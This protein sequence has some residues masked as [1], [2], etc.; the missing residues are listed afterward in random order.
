M[1]MPMGDQ[2]TN[3][4]ENEAKNDERA[5]VRED[6][7]GTDREGNKDAATMPAFDS[8]DVPKLANEFADIVPERQFAPATVQRYLLLHCVRPQNAVAGAKKWFEKVQ[9]ELSFSN[10]SSITCLGSSSGSGGGSFTSN[11]S[12]SN[13][14]NQ[15]STDMTS[16]TD[17]TNSDGN[18][19]DSTNCQS[20]LAPAAW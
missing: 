13:N 3:A 15:S 20:Y 17:S 6:N 1:Y 12:L 4:N 18:W 5:I 14:S 16:S 19:S 2:D 8:A 10:D 9:A 11:V 7:K